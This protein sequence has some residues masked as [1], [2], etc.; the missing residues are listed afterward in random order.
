MAG[1]NPLV[2]DNQDLAKKVR[3]EACE[4][5]ATRQIPRLR[6]ASQRMTQREPPLVR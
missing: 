5:W 2:V 6:F 1:M 4:D 3:A